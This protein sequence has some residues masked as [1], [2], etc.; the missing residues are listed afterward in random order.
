MGDWS[1]SDRR[2][3]HRH[4]GVGAKRAFISILGQSKLIYLPKVLI[5]LKGIYEKNLD[6]RRFF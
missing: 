1:N 3:K 2:L 4:I 5:L 6:S